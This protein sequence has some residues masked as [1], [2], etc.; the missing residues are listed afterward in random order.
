MNDDSQ[1]EEILLFDQNDDCLLP[2]ASSDRSPTTFASGATYLSLDDAQCLDPLS[3][4]NLRFFYADKALTT[5]TNCGPFGLRGCQV[6]DCQ[7]YDCNTA[8]YSRLSS[9]C[10]TNQLHNVLFAHCGFAVGAQDYCAEVDAEQVAADVLSFSDPQFPVSRLNLTN[11]IV[12]GAIGH[13]PVLNTNHVANPA[14]WPFQSVN[15]GNYYLPSGSPYRSNGAVNISPGMLLDLAQRTTYA[16]ISFPTNMTITGQLTLFPQAERYSGGAPD[17]GYYYAPL[18]YTLAEMMLQGGTMTVLRGTAIGF[19]NDFIGGIILGDNSS[20]TSQG[21]P[22]QP[23]T[24]AD[25]TLVQEGPFAPGFVWN[26]YNQND[27]TYGCSG[28]FQDYG[29]PAF[30]VPDPAT[31]DVVDAAPELNMRFC[32]FYMTSDDYAVSAGWSQPYDSGFPYSCASAVVWN[33]QDCGLY[34]G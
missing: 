26:Q 32:N 25:N 23:I 19:R 17:L 31:N 15:D 12:Y 1:G 10:S 14:T 7:F 20:F 24:F 27:F 30:L 16:P 21:T 18:D 13:G 11:A 4:T 2:A 9:G 22:T 34:G 8:I 3:I 28:D 33:M 5:P 29:G 6:W